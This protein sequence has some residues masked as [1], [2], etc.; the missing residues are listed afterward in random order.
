[1]TS[2]T[3]KKDPS[4]RSYLQIELSDL[5]RLAVLAR[6][7][8]E[9]FFSARPDWSLYENRLICTALCQGAALHYV[10]GETGIND[11]D[12]Y[13]FY[14]ADPR[15]RWYAKRIKQM[16]FADPKFGTSEESGDGFVGRRVDLLGRE[17]QVAVGA[18]PIT[19]IKKYL[20]EARTAS[21]TH[22]AE[23]PV[24]LLEPSELL[25]VIAWP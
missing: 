22:L 1:M 24:V 12:V 10:T 6:Q 16:D 9:A 14:A 23:K 5:R 7:D 20:T 25:G 17:L 21:A 15:R 18:D 4:K 13:S 11:F 2:A 19:A 8:R 3:V